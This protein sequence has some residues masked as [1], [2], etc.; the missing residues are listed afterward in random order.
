MS[1]YFNTVSLDLSWITFSSIFTYNASPHKTIITVKVFQTFFKVPVI[2][3]HDLLFLNRQ[4]RIALLL[5]I[6]SK[7]FIW[8]FIKV[9]LSRRLRFV[10]GYCRGA[11]EH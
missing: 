8:K 5:C 4:Y 10:K 3:L 1:F 2:G 9:V 11:P 7:N 6:I